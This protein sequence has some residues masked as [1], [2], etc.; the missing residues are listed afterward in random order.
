[1]QIL[2]ELKALRLMF[3]EVTQGGNAMAAKVL[4]E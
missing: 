4:A 1:M 3:E 2:E